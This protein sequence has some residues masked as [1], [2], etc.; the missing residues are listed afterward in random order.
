MS[1][2]TRALSAVLAALALSALPACDEEDRS[3]QTYSGASDSLSFF[4]ADDSYQMS[5]ET[6]ENTCGTAMPSGARQVEVIGSAMDDGRPFLNMSN[7]VDPM[8]GYPGVT[9]SGATEPDFGL[10]MSHTPD[11]VMFEASTTG[12]T[13]LT[14]E[15]GSASRIVIR[16]STTVTDPTS[17]RIVHR[18]VLTRNAAQPGI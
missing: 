8:L 11:V 2:R 3:F 12:E 4:A 13:T 7:R 6:L 14:I 1:I 10:F 18:I 15:E 9:D 5:Y 16:Q 17:C